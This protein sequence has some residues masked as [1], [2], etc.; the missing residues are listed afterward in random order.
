MFVNKYL[1]YSLILRLAKIEEIWNIF[2][3]FDQAL[4]LHLIET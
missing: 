2:V 1:R 3:F 4:R